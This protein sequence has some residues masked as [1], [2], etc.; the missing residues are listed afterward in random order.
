M[1]DIT[2]D[3]LRSAWRRILTDHHLDVPQ[4]LRA[5]AALERLQALLRETVAN[6]GHTMMEC[7]VQA[8][9]RALSETG[10]SDI[11]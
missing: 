3:E 11:E 7:E 1:T 4:L 6:V 8:I 10:L 2:P 9:T 5:A